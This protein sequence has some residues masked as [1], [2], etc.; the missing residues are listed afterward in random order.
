[1]LLDDFRAKQSPVVMGPG[2][3]RDDDVGTHLHIPAARCARVMPGISALEKQR[4]RGKPGVRCTRS[5]AW[6]VV[7]TRVSHHRFTGFI[8]L[9]PRNGFYGF[10]RALPGDRALLSPSPADIGVS[11]PL[12]LTSPSTD[13]T[14]ASG[15]Q[16]RRSIFW[17]SVK[18]AET[19]KP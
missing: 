18:H 19:K 13:L 5:R 2:V 6:G 11:G 15:R 16:D 1:M 7:N 8:R 9:S 4:A 10:P 17:Y 12:G 14:P 3:R